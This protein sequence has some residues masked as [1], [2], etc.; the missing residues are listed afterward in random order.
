M[1]KSRFCVLL[2]KRST[3]ALAILGF[4]FPLSSQQLE[5]RKL[6]L[7]LEGIVNALASIIVSPK[8]N[9][10]FYSRASTFS[11]LTQF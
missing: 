3:E 10:S 1:Q 5:L 2:G 6:L 11:L 8:V 9:I 7:V 4:T